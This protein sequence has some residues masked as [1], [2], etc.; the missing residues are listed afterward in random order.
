MAKDV[1]LVRASMAVIKHHNQKPLEEERVYIL[2]HSS[3]KDVRAGTQGSN[4][5][6]RT[7]AKVMEERCLQT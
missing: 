3:L 6:A 7:E 4:L 2:G 1:D 5:G